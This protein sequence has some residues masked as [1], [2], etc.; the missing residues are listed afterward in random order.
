MHTC[1]FCVP[2]I[3]HN[4]SQNDSREPKRR[5]IQDAHPL[6][7]ATVPSQ[8]NLQDDVHKHQEI[9][10]ASPPLPATVFS[11]KNLQ[12][13][14]QYARSSQYHRHVFSQLGL[15]L[16]FIVDPRNTNTVTRM[17]FVFQLQL[18]IASMNTWKEIEVLVHETCGKYPVSYHHLAWLMTCVNNV[19]LGDR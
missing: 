18:A 1:R 2:L 12:D 3:S 19:F 16:E 14:V 11:Q 15:V 8:Q 5:E 10:G 6:P 13:D 7:P 4:S 17:V 9:Q